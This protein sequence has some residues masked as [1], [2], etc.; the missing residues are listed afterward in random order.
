MQYDTI[1]SITITRN[2]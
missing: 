1:I 2:M